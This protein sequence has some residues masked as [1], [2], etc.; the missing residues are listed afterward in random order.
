[1]N[2]SIAGSGQFDA[3]FDADAVL[4]DPARPSRMQADY[5]SGDHLH[6][7]DAGYRALAKALDLGQL[8]GKKPVRH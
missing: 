7:G 3:V 1:M 6:P 2:R 5:D 8:M 4:R